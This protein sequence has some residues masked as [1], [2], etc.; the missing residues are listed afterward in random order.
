KMPF[1]IVER[2]GDDLRRRGIERVLEWTGLLVERAVAAGAVHGVDL[3]AVDEVVGGGRGGAVDGGGGVIHGSVEGGHGDAHLHV[4]GGGV[5]V[6]GHK[7]KEQE[8]S[9]GREKHDQRDDY[10]QDE[11]AH[12]GLRS[13]RI[14]KNARS[15]DSAPASLRSPLLRSG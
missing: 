10:A 3:H 2:I 4:A 15:L 9:G 13:M 11:V 12:G 5:G 1:G 14:G 8:A 6:G 7:A